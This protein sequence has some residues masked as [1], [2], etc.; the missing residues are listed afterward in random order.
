MLVL[1]MLIW[2]LLLKFPDEVTY[3][4]LLVLIQRTSSSSLV[5]PSP[6]PPTARSNNCLFFL[7]YLSRLSCPLL[8]EIDRQK[9]K[10]DPKAIS[11]LYEEIMEL[12]KQVQMKYLLERPLDD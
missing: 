12:T 11:D 10:L 4:F 9:G 3:P 6:P 7:A 1:M 8:E 2:T 5:S